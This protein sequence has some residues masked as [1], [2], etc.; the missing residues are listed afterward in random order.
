MWTINLARVLRTGAQC[1]LPKAYRHGA[2]GW[3]ALT[4]RA[5]SEFATRQEVERQREVPYLPH[6]A[7]PTL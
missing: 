3:S 6:P 4:E 7:P 2:R 1:L 5:L